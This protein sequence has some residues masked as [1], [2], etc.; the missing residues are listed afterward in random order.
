[1]MIGLPV[2]AY[3]VDLEGLQPFGIPLLLLHL[4]ER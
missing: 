3:A 4:D 1:M 2:L